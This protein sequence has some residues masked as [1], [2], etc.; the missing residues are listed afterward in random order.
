MNPL[1]AIANL[2]G[3]I[4]GGVNR[5]VWAATGGAVIAA[6]FARILLWV[7]QDPQFPIGLT[8]PPE[9][10]SDIQDIINMAVPA[11]GAL[12]GG[13]IVPERAESVPAEVG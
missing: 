12:L 7:L 2:P 10:A 1:K 4:I 13:Y 11:V 8:I 9:I 3:K 6:P 5:K